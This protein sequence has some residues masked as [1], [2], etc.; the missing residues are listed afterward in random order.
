MN[1]TVGHVQQ[2]EFKFISLIALL[3]HSKTNYIQLDKQ[4]E[5]HQHSLG[6]SFLVWSK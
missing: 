5:S 6:L 3:S 1:T 4:K 2:S